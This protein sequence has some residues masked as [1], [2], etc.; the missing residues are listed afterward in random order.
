MSKRKRNTIR[1]TNTLLS[2]LFHLLICIAVLFLVSTKNSVR[3]IARLDG[4]LFPRHLGLWDCIRRDGFSG[5]QSSL[6]SMD[7][8][9]VIFIFEQ[10]RYSE[11]PWLSVTGG[12]LMYTNPT[13]SLLYIAHCD[14]RESRM[15][16]LFQQW[17]IAGQWLHTN[18]A[19][20]SKQRLW[21]WCHHRRESIGWALRVCKGQ[22]LV[23]LLVFSEL[24]Y[25]YSF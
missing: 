3:F 23:T 6:L 12:T 10:H 19:A 14:L 18:N 5:V 20:S 25:L 16:V 24:F 1:S 7:H 15:Y 17:G 9:R 13:S 8:V 2:V 4:T 21:T 11:W 22:P